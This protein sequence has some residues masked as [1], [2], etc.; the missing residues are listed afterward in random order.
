MAAEN[1]LPDS[2]DVKKKALVRLTVAGL[3]TAAALGG[4]WLLDHDKPAPATQPAAQPTPAPI[5]AADPQPATPPPS[6]DQAADATL[7]LE[8]DAL[9]EP[10]AME[11]TEAATVPSPGQEPG[12]ALRS[13]PPPPRVTNTPTVPPRPAASPR[14]D[15]VSAL[16]ATATPAP[17]LPPVPPRF[18]PPGSG[19]LV[20]QMGVFSEPARAEELVQRL[21]KQGISARMETRVYVGPFLNRQEADKAREEMKRLGLDGLITTA[22]PKK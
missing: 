5:R 12:S 22:A 20:V 2:E 14:P 1:D 11:G 7:P 3:V 10:P 6:L 19:N 15:V 13:P 18:P 8:D 9:P 4:L 21:R 16:P 17:G